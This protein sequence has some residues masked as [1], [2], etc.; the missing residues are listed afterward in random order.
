MTCPN[1][2]V[3]DKERVGDSIEEVGDVTLSQQNIPG[4]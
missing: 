1:K 2:R 3:V 4:P